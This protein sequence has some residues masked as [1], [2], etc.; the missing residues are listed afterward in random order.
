MKKSDDADDH[1]DRRALRPRVLAQ[2]AH[3]HRDVGRGRDVDADQL[4]AHHVDHGGQQHGQDQLER[5]PRRRTAPA[6]P[7]SRP[8]TGRA[9][10]IRRAPPAPA[11]PGWRGTAGARCRTG[12]S[13]TGGR[14]PPSSRPAGRC[15]TRRA[16]RAR[17]GP[18]RRRFPSCASIFRRR[19]RAASRRSCF[20]CGVLGAERHP[21]GRPSRGCRAVDCAAPVAHHGLARNPASRIRSTCVFSAPST[22]LAYSGPLRNVVLKAPSSMN[23]FQSGVSRTFLNRST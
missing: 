4:D 7:R 18:A 11:S 2:P 6:A 23:F 20:P 21:R 8:G 12:N 1:A 22:H 5:S 19:R 3:E 10:S 13:R 9:A 17:T 14:R 16:R 15:R